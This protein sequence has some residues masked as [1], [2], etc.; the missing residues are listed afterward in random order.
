L[1]VEQAKAALLTGSVVKASLD[2][3]PG[4]CADC[5]NGMS[6]AEWLEKTNYQSMPHCEHFGTGYNLVRWMEENG[7]WP[8]EK[9]TV[10]SA[11]SV[12]RARMIQVIE[13][14][15]KDSAAM[16]DPRTAMKARAAALFR[17]RVEQSDRTV[18][19]EEK[20]RV[21]RERAKM[22][23]LKAERRARGLK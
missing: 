15:W 9:P 12:G 10:H 21:E 7:I 1:T 22:P 2:H 3:D 17:E 16:T 6:P 5:L 23:R 18:L 14:Y 19:A 20:A 4:C 11:N 8:K 13:K